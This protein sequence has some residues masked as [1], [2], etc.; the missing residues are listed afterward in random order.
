M[1]FTGIIGR[2]T[3]DVTSKTF[4]GSG[5]TVYNFSLALSKN[6]RNS[7]GEF[8]TI[9]VD[10]QA[11]NS[12]AE[13]LAKYLK[14]GTMV[15]VSG[16]LDNKKFTDR[17]SGKEYTTIIVVASRI[18]LCGGKREDSGTTNTSARNDTPPHKPTPPPTET[19]DDDDF[20]F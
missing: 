13:N 7:D 11:W 10:V 20:P 18:D 3:R 9:F 1:N 6:Y 2:L 19:V 14:K 15:A 12:V 5:K 17:E 8:D 16:S 4:E